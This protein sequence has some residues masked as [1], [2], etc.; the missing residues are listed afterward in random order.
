MLLMV[1]L[2]A[3][4]RKREAEAERR[5][6]AEAELKEAHVR[7]EE[8]ERELEGNLKKVRALTRQLEE[9]GAQPPPEASP[10]KRLCVAEEAVAE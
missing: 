8:L 1:E 5:Q 4:T 10:S 9:A 3:E 7:I 2:T 6:Q